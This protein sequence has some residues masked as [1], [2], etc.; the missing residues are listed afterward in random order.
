MDLEHKINRFK[1]YEDIV[2][3]SGYVEGMPFEKNSYKNLLG[4]YRLIPKVM[5]CF[6]NSGRICHTPHNRGFVVEL[7]SGEVTI[8]GNECVKKL[9]SDEK[10]LK[11]VKVL[12]KEE[13]RQDKIQ[14]LKNRLKTPL[15]T[16]AQ[17]SDMFDR[18]MG[19]EKSANDFL[20][21]MPGVVSQYLRN[22]VK[23]GNENISV[24]LTYERE[25]YENGKRKIET[26]EIK[27]AVYKIKG[28]RF[29]NYELIMP[30][31]MRLSSVKGAVK[32]VDSINNN[33]SQRRISDIAN[34]LNIY[35][36]QIKSIEDF[37]R[38]KNEFMGNDF[39]FFLLL[40]SLLDDERDLYKSLAPYSK[41][42]QK[43][44]GESVY[45]KVKTSI[46]NQSGAV[47]IHLL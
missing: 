32:A 8:V 10:L 29:L 43:I 20:A 15:A 39:R 5:C 22:K 6:S 44:G 2:S 40:A 42:I 26:E 23:T 46:L 38:Y 3:V 34:D 21:S 24:V 16:Y 41:D 33:T 4:S 37:E 27:T 12:E 17:V 14:S 7:V 30:V 11:D 28:L 13:N 31:K 19:V 47:S 9:G 35:Q 18:A 36:R 45:K 1:S 25:Y